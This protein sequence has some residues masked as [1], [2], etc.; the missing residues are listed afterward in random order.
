MKSSVQA[1]LEFDFRG[2][3]YA[4]S[5]TIDLDAMMHGQGSLNGLH[6]LLASSIG[7][8]PYRHEYDV[9]ILE[10]IIFSEPAG[11]ACQFVHDGLLN[12]DGFIKTWETRK[13]LAMIHPIAEKYLNISDL[14]KHKDIET[15][16]IESY[17]AGQKNKNGNT[18]S[19]HCSDFL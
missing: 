16:L 17:K 11:L 13:I 6:D 3:R 4:P 5:I 14:S 2:E 19:V 12:F 15:A 1:S 7:L 8:D 9:L 18:D 10:D